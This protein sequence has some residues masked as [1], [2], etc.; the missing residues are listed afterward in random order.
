MTLL[1]SPGWG[2]GAREFMGAEVQ[3]HGGEDRLGTGIPKAS[4]VGVCFSASV[5]L[6]LPPQTFRQN[7]RLDAP[8]GSVP[9]S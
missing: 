2:Q 7:W 6:M 3:E 8:T 1:P 9:P 4:V 5:G